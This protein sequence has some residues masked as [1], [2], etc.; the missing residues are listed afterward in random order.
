LDSV[1]GVGFRVDGLRGNDDGDERWCDC[2]RILLVVSSSGV[3]DSF[4][5]L[6]FLYLKSKL[7]PRGR[8]DDDRRWAV[9]A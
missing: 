2:C 9:S 1:A 8:V 6:T 5:S 7:Q 3:F 4:S